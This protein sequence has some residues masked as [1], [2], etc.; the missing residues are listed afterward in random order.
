MD[1]CL[2]T[3]TL[4]E[5]GSGSHPS[6]LEHRQSWVLSSC[7]L[8]ST[9]EDQAVLLNARDSEHFALK[10]QNENLHRLEVL[11]INRAVK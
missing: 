10:K 1:A 6:T 3:Y 8:S 7:A 4:L 9:E 11:N 5:Q 2:W